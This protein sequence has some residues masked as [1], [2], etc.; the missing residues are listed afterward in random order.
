MKSTTKS[1]HS[2][3]VN[4]RKGHVGSV[5][6][7]VH[8]DHHK[9]SSAAAKKGQQALSE[10]L[11]ANA[12]SWKDVEIG[13]SFTKND[14]L[15][16]ITE[17]T[18]V[19]GMDVGSEKHHVRA[20]DYRGVEYSKKP[21]AFPNN[22]PGFEMFQEWVLHICAAQGKE[23]V[24]VGQEPTGHYWFNIARWMMDHGMTVVHVNPHH[25]KRSKELDDNSQNKTDSKDPRVI[26]G[27]VNEGRYSMPYLPEG[28]YAQLRELSTLRLMLTEDATRIRNRIQ[29]WLSIHF[30]EYK[31]VYQ[32]FGVAGSM[33]LLQKAP[34]PSDMVRL[35][36]EGI[37]R[38][39]RDARL[40]GSGKARAQAIIEAASSSI[41]R[42]EAQES[43]RMELCILLSDYR[44]K[45]EQQRQVEEELERL[46]SQIP[47]MEDL[48]EVR[49]L[50]LRT[51]SG[52]LAELGDIRRF[53]GAGQL[54]KLAGL[55][56]VESSSG[57]HAGKTVISKRGRKR[58]RYLLYETSLSLVR[59][60]PEFRELHHYYTCRAGHPLKKM[61]SLMAVAG[62]LLRV[63]YAMLTK[64]V[65]YDPEKLVRDIRRPGTGAV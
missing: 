25:V 27:L 48:L 30:P 44:Q 45:Q 6:N 14:K 56:L 3:E 9:E 64:Q 12:V 21:L 35:G 8:P 4:K 18:L 17:K 52:I 41:G 49:G 55:A 36:E 15:A 29:R 42:R 63:I 31:T 24:V 60:N 32:D 5:T 10:I 53:N 28:V 19:V 46:G 58:L 37:Q 50:G 65:R 23:M 16:R 38:I 40:R 13:R 33:L 47:Q 7:E 2:Q 20:F 51:V 57:K 34:L 62:K 26:A 11:Q 43:A 22:G 39:W 61:Q 1:N 59:S 54:V